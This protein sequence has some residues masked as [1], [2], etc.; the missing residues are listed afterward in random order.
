M[1]LP[2][3]SE[4]PAVASQLVVVGAGAE[5]RLS[6]TR[7][8]SARDHKRLCLPNNRAPATVGGIGEF[9]Q[10]MAPQVDNQIHD[11]HLIPADEQWSS[12]REQLASPGRCPTVTI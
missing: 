4:V 1:P 5:G 7:F 6:A 10:I 12:R 2:V 8:L 11:E 3:L 9:M